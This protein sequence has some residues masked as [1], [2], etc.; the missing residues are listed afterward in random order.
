MN[1]VALNIDTIPLGS[2]LPFA[3]RGSD[4]V[5]LAKKGYVIRDRADLESLLARGQALYLDVRESGDNHRAYVSQLQ[6]MLRS[7]T[8]LGQIAS[9]KISANTISLSTT[10]ERENTGPMGWHELQLHATQLLRV[11]N[12]ADFAGRFQTLHNDLVL[13]TTQAPDATLLALI[14]LSAQEI[15]MYSATHAMLVAVACMLTARETLRWPELRIQQVGQAA[16]SMNI[17]M[18]AMQ[19]QLAQQTQPLSG[20]QITAIDSHPAHSA[21]LLHHLGVAD[22]V[23]LEAVRLHHQRT[24]G[25]LAQKSEAEQIARLIQRA[26]VFG[27]RI[28]PRASRLPMPV[29][30]AMQVSYYDENQQVDEAGAALVKTLGIYPPGA[31]VRLASQ[32]VGIVLRRGLSATTPR[33]AVV[34]GR[35]G[36]PTGELIPRD[37]A[38]ANWKITG[39]VA[40]KSVRVS[41]PLERILALAL[42]K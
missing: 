10:R 30:A 37:T 42:S 8:Q 5:L 17:A 28:S 41:W 16:L 38:L 1:L 2:P 3:L 13:H 35:S 32:E 18:T 33:V 11:P 31:L 14:H 25:P 19:D 34:V 26:D 40:H 21:T 24:P 6:E 12:M 9:M 15:H 4:G 29:T 22:P 27:A 23:W 7:D 36:M 20:P 39:P